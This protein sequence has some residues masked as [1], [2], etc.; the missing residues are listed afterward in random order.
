VLNNEK[1]AL[2]LLSQLPDFRALREKSR[3]KFLEFSTHPRNGRRKRMTHS[4]EK[5][6]K[7]ILAHYEDYTNRAGEDNRATSSRS[8]SVEFHYTKKILREF[9]GKNDSVIE[10][11]CGTGYYGMHFA[12]KCKEYVGID[13]FPCHIE[14]F[15][16]KIQESGIKNLSCNVN[17]ATNLKGIGDSSFDVVLCLGPMYH[18]PSDIREYAIAEC[19]R[20]CKLGGIIAFAFVNK[21][22]TYF[23]A[24]LHEDLRN[25]YPNQEANE[26]V[27]KEG[28]NDTEKPFFFTT[29][30]EMK[31]AA[32]RHGLTKI[33]TAGL[34]FFSL[35]AFAD[36]MN[37][38]KFGFYLELLDQATSHE[39]C[40]GMSEH[41]LLICKKGLI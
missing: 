18:L 23:A 25:V 21:I 26:K 29:P 2:A 32:A 28:V 16:R 5:K 37:D 41:A 19:K 34:D 13:L 33:R 20:V 3:A 9:I 27:L 40:A 22:G 24:C 35:T 1:F 14:I 39:S 10:V 15:Q 31:S 12:N 38:E 30:E 8:A 17:D 6:K 7:K 11:G 4:G 36:K